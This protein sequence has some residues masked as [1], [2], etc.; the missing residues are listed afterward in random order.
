LAGLVLHD[1]RKDR[2]MRSSFGWKNGQKNQKLFTDIT[3]LVLIAVTLLNAQGF[4][5]LPWAEATKCSF[6]PSQWEGRKNRITEAADLR[7]MRLL[8]CR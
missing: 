2:K 6:V 1:F 7:L 3:A 8:C 4:R 5:Q